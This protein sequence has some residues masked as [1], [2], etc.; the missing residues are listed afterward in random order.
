MWYENPGVFS[1]AQLTQIKQTSLARI[2]CDNA[3]NITR[4]QRDVFRVAE[5]PHGYGSCDEVPRV[6]LRVW[7][8]CCEDCRTR[9]QFNAFSYHFRGKRSLEF[10]YQEDEPT[11]E[12]GPAGTPSIGKR[13]KHPGN[14]T[15]AS[16]EHPQVPG[17]NDFKDF[18]L[19]MQ[20]TITDL[21]E[22]IKRLESRLSTADCTD[23]DGEPHANGAKWKRDACTACE[24][25]DGQVTCFVE[26]CQPAEC[27]A[28]VRARGACCPVC[29][30]DG[31]GRKP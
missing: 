13:R 6:D 10:S 24:C 8:D 19:E 25:R 7:Q 26:A 30:R 14:A 22:Q 29:P 9:G 28:P 23:A 5:F 17:A 15:A 31:V 2:L 18:V 11:G 20:K 16:G 27:P 3:D 21:R 12:A 1:P 4:V